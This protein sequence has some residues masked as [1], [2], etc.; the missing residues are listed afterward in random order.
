MTLLVVVEDWEDSEEEKGAVFS[1]FLG[2]QA[3]SVL[4]H[5]VFAKFLCRSSVSSIVESSESSD[6]L[7]LRLRKPSK[8]D[9]DTEASGT[10]T[11]RLM[12]LAFEAIETADSTCCSARESTT[13]VF[14]SLTS[15]TSLGTVELNCKIYSPQRTPQLKSFVLRSSSAV[16]ISESGQ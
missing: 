8:T 11:G 4:L 7:R 5:V 9:E 15:V 13:S 6:E 12:M 10:L 14:S 16:Y 1:S 3:C 2:R